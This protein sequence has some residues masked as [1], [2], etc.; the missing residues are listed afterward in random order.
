M[1]YYQVPQRPRRESVQR[2]KQFRQKKSPFAWSS[3]VPKFQTQDIFHYFEQKPF[4]AQIVGI[5]IITLAIILSFQTL[6]DFSSTKASSNFTNQEQEVRILSNFHEK[7]TDG[8]VVKTVIE[9]IA[10]TKP[11]PVVKKEDDKKP[12]KEEVYTVVEADTLSSIASK[13]STTSK[14]LIEK[15]GIEN[16]LLIQVGDILAIPN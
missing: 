7:K 9:E 6:T 4:I 10:N 8:R 15:N 5:S 13:F 1:R 3:L 14:A 11:A 12:V 16:P 2:R